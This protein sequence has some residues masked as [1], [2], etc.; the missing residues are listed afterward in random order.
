MEEREVIFAVTGATLFVVG[1][2]GLLFWRFAQQRGVL[3]IENMRLSQLVIQQET[4]LVEERKN[5][6]EKLELVKA[7]HEKFTETFKA[8]SADALQQNN[9]S[10]LTLAKASLEK[11]QE[12]AKGDL[13]QRQQAIDNLVKPIKQSLE[14]VDQ[15][16]A[17]L[18]K[19]RASAYGGLSEQVKGLANAQTQL[20]SETANLVKAL[21]Q[22]TVRGRWGEMQLRR[23]VEMA[24]MVEQCDFVCQTTTNSD[25]GQRRPDLLVKLP[26]D[27]Q[28]VVDA[29]TPLSAYLE[30]L[31]EKDEAMAKFKLQ[32][33]ARQIRTHI[34]QL[35]QKN[36][37][38]Q[39]QPTP[40]FVILFI[41]GES[42]LS[43]AVEQD[44]ALIEFGIDRKVIVAT[45]ATL[46]AM[47]RSVA[48]GWR[49]E[50]IA[51][52]MVQISELGQT[53][54]DRLRVF[55]GHFDDVRKGL[56]RAVESYN[57]AVGSFETRV[58][59]SAR[60]FHDLG[61]LTGAEI[62]E[63]QQIDVQPRATAEDAEPAEVLS[64]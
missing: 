40:D 21:R 12:G 25:Y 63:L 49:Q 33:H 19:A 17:E 56:F 52:N 15:K 47:L 5:A 42:F 45:P 50:A 20:Q 23:V 61:T 32:E 34:L 10:F 58:L 1:A 62:E 37:W 16:I 14:Q 27:H 60:K 43:A 2:L 8:L 57:K 26:N 29:K 28:I 51:K 18:E 35:S 39:F 55:T 64:H 9:E 30:A 41:P 7:S 36:Y 22:P 48:F 3:L 59:V 53:L 54:Y 4:Q 46:I 11:Y 38:A 6:Q 31:E 13:T 44:P 24:G